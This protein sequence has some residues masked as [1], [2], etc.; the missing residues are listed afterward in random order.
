MRCGSRI[1]LLPHQANKTPVAIFTGDFPFDAQ[2]RFFQQGAHIGGGQQV[3]PVPRERA[4]FLILS[5]RLQ[6]DKHD[7]IEGAVVLIPQSR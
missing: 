4:F 5:L 1:A 7:I 6:H 2:A 3:Q